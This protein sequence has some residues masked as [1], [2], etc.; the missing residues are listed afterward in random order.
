M[1]STEARG[2][3]EL[4]FTGIMCCCA[5]AVV[6][7]M[8]HGRATTH[9][10]P[11][12]I[13]GPP[14]LV[15]DWQELSAVGHRLGG[16]RPVLT[17]VEFGDFEC[18]ACRGYEENVLR[19]FKEANPQDVAVVFRHFPLNYHRFAM[20]TARISECAAH[21][22]RFEAFFSEIYRQQDSL[23]LK[24]YWQFAKDVG[25]RDSSAFAACAASRADVPEIQRDLE[26]G[27]K[28]GVTGTPTIV[29]QG[30]V[31]KSLPTR[32]ELDSALIATTQEKAQ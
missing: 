11:N 4:A 3:I 7:L 6:V 8:L 21:E 20:P 26:A 1:L 18:P 13:Y 27:K 24:S 9:R 22:G 30:W 2:H 32:A 14:T 16:E 19:P 12:P 5:I 29:V 17:L 15:A 31:F 25:L 10:E 23:G 28:L